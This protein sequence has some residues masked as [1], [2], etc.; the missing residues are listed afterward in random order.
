MVEID[1]AGLDAAPSR[2]SSLLSTHRLQDS[3]SNVEV[4]SAYFAA[5]L[6][7]VRSKTRMTHQRA[8]VFIYIAPKP[9]PPVS[10][11]YTA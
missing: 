7:R 9:Q 8:E 3:V 1:C 2:Q 10:S 11:A 4:C 6:H 5:S